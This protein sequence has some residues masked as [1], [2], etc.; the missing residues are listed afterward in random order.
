MAIIRISSKCA[1]TARTIIGAQPNPCLGVD[2]ELD[3]RN[4]WKLEETSGLTASPSAGTAVGTLTNMDGSEWTGA[5]LSF[6]GVNDNLNMGLNVG[7]FGTGSYSLAAWIKPRSFKSYVINPEQDARSG[8]QTIIGNGAELNPGVFD[9]ALRGYW[10]VLNGDKLTHIMSDN[11][12]GRLVTE[13]TTSLVTDRWY[14]VGVVVDK[15]EETVTLYINGVAQG[16]IGD[17]TPIG[18]QSSGVTFNVGGKNAGGV[19]SL[20][21]ELADVRT[22]PVAVPGET[23]LCLYRQGE[24]AEPPPPPPPATLSA[25]CVNDAFTPAF[26]G[27]D[28]SYN[29]TYVS[30]GYHEGAVYFTKGNFYS[31]AFYLQKVDDYWLISDMLESSPPTSAFGIY[32]PGSS[33]TEPTVGVWTGVE[34]T[35]VLSHGGGCY[36][37][38]SSFCVTAGQAFPPASG[39]DGTY[40]VMSDTDIQGS[41]VYI[42]TEAPTHYLWS[43][44]GVWVVSDDISSPGPLQAFSNGFVGDPT[45]TL[46]NIVSGTG[47]LGSFTLLSGACVSTEPPQPAGDYCTQGLWD[48]DVTGEWFNQGPNPNPWDQQRDYWQN[49]K[50]H[51]LYATNE[52]FW[53]IS[54]TLNRALDEINPDLWFQS[55]YFGPFNA[56]L[57]PDASFFTGASAWETSYGGISAGQYSNGPCQAA[58]PTDCGAA[59]LLN[60]TSNAKIDANDNQY[61]TPSLHNLEGTVF[62]LQ[63]VNNL[64]ANPQTPFPGSN[65]YLAT[66]TAYGNL[67][68]W[69]EEFSNYWYISP[70]L[71][72]FTVGAVW[73]S[74]NAYLD[75]P[76]K[77]DS[78]ATPD[79]TIGL[80]ISGDPCDLCA[81]A[82][83][84]PFGA[85]P[86]SQ[87]EFSLAREDFE[88]CY[89]LNP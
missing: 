78:T 81:Y 70:Q 50:G 21:G 20:D 86:I 29:G 38:V 83:Y 12:S 16:N 46:F 55:G 44:A 45:G 43:D 47:P 88:G 33:D 66:G 64:P 73:F 24:P 62:V 56:P 31:G 53:F 79:G 25:V 49:E 77:D 52:G 60:P 23:M 36:P 2:T 72:N 87:G 3:I 80:P 27:F 18:T 35:M 85:S 58:N 71:N 9:N 32:A 65:Y 37:P 14:H 11:D 61:P 22:Y 39:M 13:A 8:F 6:D 34:G 41:N 1:F 30:G 51:Y 19:D 17:S 40:I 59:A 67:Y 42:K 89:K 54:P 15:V 68:L 7:D 63:G 48:P 4:W 57:V 10:W 75:Y 28:F 5:S 84:T 74:P 76:W 82:S 69:R 26:P